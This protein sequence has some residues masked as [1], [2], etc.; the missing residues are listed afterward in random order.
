MDTKI[1][2]QQNVFVL[3]SIELTYKEN[4][5]EYKG[6]REKISSLIKLE[7]TV[8]PK[9]VNS[10]ETNIELY[11]GVAIYNKLDK[12][13]SQIYQLRRT[14]KGDDIFILEISPC[15][16]DIEYRM[17]KKKNVG[18]SKDSKDEYIDVQHSMEN[19]RY[20]TY[21]SPIDNTN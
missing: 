12:S 21:Y 8:I 11:N 14:N 18:D 3:I 13:A 7:L 6:E 9:E 16:N 5:D 20:I 15:S 19:G 10:D 17:L 1:E 2:S 4:T